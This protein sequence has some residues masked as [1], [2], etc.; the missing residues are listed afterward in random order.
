VTRRRKPQ[1]L[2]TDEVERGVVRLRGLLGMLEAAKVPCERGVGYDHRYCCTVHATGS[3][4]HGNYPPDRQR[5]D[6]WP[7]IA[8]RPA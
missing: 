4:E 5:C 8:A 1:P 7:E 2:Y 3:A 6:A